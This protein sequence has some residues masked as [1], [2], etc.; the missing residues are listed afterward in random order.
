LKPI[1]ESKKTGAYL[2]VALALVGLAWLVSPRPI[3]STSF[4]DQGKPFFPD[5]TDPNSAISL[6]VVSYDQLTGSAA[7]FKV[8]FKNDRWVIPSHH[9]YPADAK[10]RLAKTA[11]GVID[12]KR[13]E[14]RSQNVAD[15]PQ[16][17]VVD[18]LDDKVT[19][20]AGRGTRVT[21]RGAGDKL[22]ADFIVGNPVQGK[23]G[24]RFVRVPDETRV[25]AA[26][27][28]ADLS[29]RFED[30]INRDLLEIAKSDVSKIAWNDYSVNPRTGGV[31][32]R[33]NFGIENKAGKWVT[34]KPNLGQAVDSTKMQSL[35]AALGLQIVGVRPKPPALVQVLQGN[36]QAQLTQAEVVSLQTKGFYISRSG[37][38]L[39]NDGEMAVYL[40]DGVYYMLR[41]GEIMYGAGSSL[42]AGSDDSAA[43]PSSGGTANRYLFVT[44]SYDPSFAKEPLRPTGNDWRTKPDSL[45]SEAEKANK[46]VGIEHDRWQRQTEG[47]KQK[48]NDLNTRFSDWYY[49]VSE[50]SFSKI[51]VKRSDLTTHTPPPKT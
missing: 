49:V 24:F 46:K 3:S 45:M 25:Y 50:D 43:A 7:P 40:N 31:E 13:D 48:A 2:V 51:H 28:D 6:Q 33:D 29:P 15:Y 1:T 11:A 12:I 9:D 4:N 36:T 10:D 18:P 44:A 5:F 20:L 37:Q 47:A 17:G 27:I 34:T 38:L 21:L 39:S 14:F 32:Q 16:F 41:F 26:K 35:L 19:G 42:T 30:W 22:L 23:S 8:E